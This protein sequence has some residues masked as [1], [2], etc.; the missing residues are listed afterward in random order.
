[1]TDYI[2]PIALQRVHGFTRQGRT[3]SIVGDMAS[4]VLLQALEELCRDADVGSALHR[5]GGGKV[6]GEDNTVD[7][8]FTVYCSFDD[9]SMP[10]G[11]Y[12]IRGPV[13]RQEDGPTFLNFGLSLFYLGSDGQTYGSGLSI[14]DIAVITNDWSL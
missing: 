7:A 8:L 5:I 9:A 2:G 11:W 13:K 6:Y 14:S 12:L 10:D 4:E 3:R 1:M